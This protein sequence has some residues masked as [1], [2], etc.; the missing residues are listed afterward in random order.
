MTSVKAQDQIPLQIS[1]SRRTLLNNENP[2]GKSQ[3]SS[4]SLPNRI[5][6]LKFGYA[7]AKFRQLAQERDDFSRSVTSSS[8]H[9]LRERING[10]FARRIDWTLLMKMGKEWIQNPMNTALFVWIMCVAISGA[11]LFLVMT[12]VLDH[13]LPKESQRDVW[14]EVNNQILNALSAL[15]C[16]YQHP[17]RF[18]DLVLL[19]RWNPKDIS[20]L[21]KIYCMNG[22]YKPH[23]WARMMVA[24]AAL[25]NRNCFA[26]YALCGLNL[27]YRRSERPA[28]GVG[29][30][31]S[32]AIAAPAAAGVYSILSPL[33]KDYE[34]EIDEEAQMQI[35]AG[36]RPEKLRP[37]SLEMNKEFLRLDH[38]GEVRAGN[39]YDIVE[40]KFC[41]KQMDCSNKMP[42]I[43]LSP[44][45]MVQTQVLHLETNSSPSKFTISNSPSPS[46]V[47]KGYNTPR[48]QLLMV[49]EES[50][51]GVK[52]ETMTPPAPSLIEREANS[53]GKEHL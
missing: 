15:M 26:Q 43:H 31:I 13:A 41:Q 16:L 10:V 53:A 38:S 1:A 8:S 30:C 46:T 51:R 29:I 47:S 36:E 6:F 42:H 14:F 22:T 28:I 17:K 19:C 24:A 20:R 48:R 4:L 34:S 37:N 39:S 9:G 49:K 50:S 44:A 12:G 27:G 21:G 23:E 11:S 25:V 45:E 52:D 32:I 7:S 35:S 3:D 5:N 40:D 18:Y 33:G 2:Q